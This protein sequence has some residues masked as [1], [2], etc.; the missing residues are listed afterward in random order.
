M[1]DLNDLN[2]AVVNK[3]RIK[4][5]KTNKRKKSKIQVNSAQKA[6]SPSKMTVG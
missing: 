4:L 5:N 6:V 1:E 2:T 3:V